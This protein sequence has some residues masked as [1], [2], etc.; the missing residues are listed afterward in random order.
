MDKQE[1]LK[2]LHRLN[3]ELALKK[4]EGEICVFG[5][6]FMVLTYNSRKS[7]KDIDAV[8]APKNEFYQAVRSLSD[9]YNL[10]PDWLNDS[11]KGF[12][13]SDFEKHLYLELSNLKILTPAPEYILVMKLM[14][15]RE[16]S[17]DEQDIKT[18]LQELNIKDSK[19][20]LDLLDTIVPE[21]LLNVRIKYRIIE[22]IEEI[23]D[24]AV[25]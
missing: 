7:T 22:L 6:A 20:V 24:N 3:E 14:A 18:L 8:F 25:L 12:I 23:W 21:K 11:V 19:Q 9:R 17:Y 15:D 10:N 13:Y 16:D 1:I 4:I 5:G 2:N